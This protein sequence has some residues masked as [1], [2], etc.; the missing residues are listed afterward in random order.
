MDIP[1]RNSPYYMVYMLLPICAQFRYANGDSTYAEFLA[2]LLVS[3]RGVPICI[4]DQILRCQQS[5]R[6]SPVEAEFCA[7]TLAHSHQ[8]P[9]MYYIILIASH[10]LFVF[11]DISHSL[12]ICDKSGFIISHY[13]LSTAS[14]TRFG[15]CASSSAIPGSFQRAP[16]QTERC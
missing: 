9:S 15:R 2:S 6:Q 13:G 11:G 1:R 8:K 10:S 4:R 12:S 7:C 5:F 3:I 14:P 16:H